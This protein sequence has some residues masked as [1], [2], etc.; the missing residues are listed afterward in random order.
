MVSALSLQ[1]KTPTSLPFRATLT[2]ASHLQRS[3]VILSRAQVLSSAH[4]GGIHIPISI[5][6][7]FGQLVFGNHL[8][9]WW[10]SFESTLG[11]RILCAAGMLGGLQRERCNYAADLCSL[12]RKSLSRNLCCSVFLVYFNT[13]L[14]LRTTAHIEADMHEG[15]YMYTARPQGLGMHQGPPTWNTFFLKLVG[16]QTLLLRAR[17]L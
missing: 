2:R 5:F 8:G 11:L 16:Q 12:S 10:V 1:L 6:Q 9:F 17:L 13:T 7:A 3:P 15:E 14:T 4:L